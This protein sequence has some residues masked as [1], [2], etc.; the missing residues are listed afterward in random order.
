MD[1]ITYFNIVPL[2]TLLL[3]AL[4]VPLSAFGFFKEEIEVDSYSGSNGYLAFHAPPRLSFADKP[5]KADRGF[6]LMLANPINPVEVLSDVEGNATSET[7]FPLVSYSESDSN[8]SGLYQIPQNINPPI[9]S[10][11]AD[12]DNVLPPADPFVPSDDPTFQ[13]VNDTDEL[14]R[15]FESG[16]V[17]H[18][19]R[20]A[21]GFQFLP[22]YTV[23]RGNMLMQ[24]SA[25]YTRKARN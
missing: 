6:L 10:L 25:T 12:D 3:V 7:D 4:L 19:S 14:M 13:S 9:L 20:V 5:T 24:S 17:D 21:E 23:E 15:L 22:P 16:V 18:S 2:N 1:K 8:Q 11:N